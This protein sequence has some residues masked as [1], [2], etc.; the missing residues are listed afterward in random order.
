M[1]IM[2]GTSEQCTHVLD[3]DSRTR[4]TAASLTLTAGASPAAG[5]NATLRSGVM[6]DETTMDHQT[7]PVHVVRCHVSPQTVIL[8]LGAKLNLAKYPAYQVTNTISV[9]AEL[10]ASE[11]LVAATSGRES[12]TQKLAGLRSLTLNGERHDVTAYVAA[13]AHHA[14]CVV[15]GLPK[16]V[17]DDQLLSIISI[18]DR[19]ILAAR[20]IGQ[21][22][23]IL[24]TVKGATIPK[25][26][27]VGLWLTKTQPFRP[28]AVQCTICLTIG[29]R[30]DVCPTAHE[31]TCCEKCGQQFP[32][33]QQPERTAHECELKCF[34][35]EGPHA[36]RD[37]RC[38]KKQQADKLAR[39]AA[40]KRRLRST[41]EDSAVPQ[42]SQTSQSRTTTP[43]KKSDENFPSL[44][45][46]NRFSAL[47]DTTPDPQPE[48]RPRSGSLPGYTTKRPAPPPP[49]PKPKTPSYIRA[50]LFQK[51]PVA[52]EEPPHKQ[53]RQG[54][55][56]KINVEPVPRN[57]DRDTQTGRR[58]ARAQ[59]LQETTGEWILYTDASLSQTGEG[60]RTGIAS[61]GLSLS[62]GFHYNIGTQCMAE[63]TAIAEAISMPNPNARCLLIRTDSQ[64]A[65]AA[66]ARGDLPDSLYRALTKHLDAHPSLRVRIQWIPGHSGIRGNE[67][68]HAMSRVS[69]PGPPLWWPDSLKRTELLA[70]ARLDRRERLDEMRNNRRVYPDPPHSMTRREAAVVGRAQTHS[71]MT[72]H[73][74]H[75]VQGKDG[76][77]SFVAC[78]GFP[79]N[80]HVLWNC[81]GGRA[82]M[83]ESLKH[84]PTKLRPA[85][86]EEWLADSSP[87]LMK[88]LLGH[89][90]LLGLSEG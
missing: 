34:N 27:K 75:Y 16:D 19:Q 73:I 51:S 47:Q 45:L 90:T 40:E 65:C 8:R 78:G 88:A 28:R 2:Q 76:S 12:A 37:P 82:A 69:L 1:D 64:A 57:M 33:G 15:H 39:I 38:P 66:F 24:L 11:N 46:Q 42:K 77:P 21:S 23:A 36:A 84:I 49:P 79:D 4:D 52:S 89:L 83:G 43:T 60:F 62:W 67:V 22:E 14:R 70:L 61:D 44:P 13:E 86:L 32:A 3:A 71:L 35:C 6:D 20:R 50:L 72:P 26:V 53:P 58:E 74:E 10:T 5:G 81:S 25:E 56:D 41:P 18:E 80:A 59:H 87:D 63:I 68:A 54:P 29:H 7:T 48:P 30:A 85:T 17:P 55:P 31:F 9:A